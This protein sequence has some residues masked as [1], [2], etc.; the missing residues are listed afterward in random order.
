MP[1]A[2]P[3]Q[4]WIELSSSEMRRLPF[5]LSRDQRSPTWPSVIPLGPLIPVPLSPPLSHLLALSFPSHQAP[6]HAERARLASFAQ[7][8]T[9]SSSGYPRVLTDSPWYSIPGYA[10]A[11]LLGNAWGG[12]R[13]LTAYSLLTHS[14][15]TGYATSRVNR[16]VGY[17]QVTQ[18]SARKAIFAAGPASELRASCSPL[19]RGLARGLRQLQ[20][21]GPAPWVA[22]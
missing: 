14:V 13:A 16:G 10:G 21:E 18:A 15:L 11:L 1:R 4:R 22:A 20:V 8:H 3:A 2:C 12:L 9:S 19:A 6:S 5:G 7:S 17:S